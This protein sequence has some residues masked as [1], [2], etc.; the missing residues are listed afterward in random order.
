MDQHIHRVLKDEE[1][2]LFAAVLA[3]ANRDL[4]GYSQGV[5]L[6]TP[7]GKLLEFS[8]TADAGQVRRMLESALRKYDPAAEQGVPGDGQEAS[9]PVPT[10]PEGGLVVTV[11][12][13]VLGGYEGVEDPRTRIHAASLGRDHLW[14]RPDEA[15]ALA[16]G[17]VPESLQRR[18]ARFHLVDNTRGEPPF[19][20]PDEVRKLEMRLE[21]GRLTGRVELESGSGTRSYRADL[22]GF[23]TASAGRVTR[24]DLVARGDYRGAGEFTGGGPKGTFPF[25]VRFQLA[26]GTS[27]V[28]RALPGAARGSVRSY[29]Q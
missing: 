21:A 16:R 19:W 13:R 24:F 4:R 9:R 10:P 17:T 26:E 7:S 28:D 27:E 2:K 3:Q 20:R 6:F 11:T 22:L 29:L 8:N 5:Y 18:I 25:A 15:E 1:G 23:V 12:S 14:V